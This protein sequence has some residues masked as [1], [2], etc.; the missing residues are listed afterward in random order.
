MQTMISI[1]VPKSNRREKS[2]TDE[3]SAALIL[4]DFLRELE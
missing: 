4:Q 1:G 2:R 3:I